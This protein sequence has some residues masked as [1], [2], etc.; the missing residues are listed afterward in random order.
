MANN[1]ESIDESEPLFPSEPEENCWSNRIKFYLD[2]GVFLLFFGWNLSGTI[3]INEILV[4]T[5]HVT[6]NFSETD[7]LELGQKHESPEVKV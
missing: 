2:P 4:Q 5:C 3:L 1:S 7:C 6:Y